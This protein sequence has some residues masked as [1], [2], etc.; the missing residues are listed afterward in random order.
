MLGTI[1]KGEAGAENLPLLVGKIEEESRSR[2]ELAEEWI[3][4]ENKD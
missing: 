3:V 2:E 1:P 4:Q